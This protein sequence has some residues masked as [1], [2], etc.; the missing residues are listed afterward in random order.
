METQRAEWN[1]DGNKPL[2]ENLGAPNADD[3]VVAENEFIDGAL[4]RVQQE[5][6]FS[7]VGT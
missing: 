1:K 7:L 2:N 5:W 4:D 3:G 6:E